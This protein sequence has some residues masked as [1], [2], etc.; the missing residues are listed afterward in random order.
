MSVSMGDGGSWRVAVG[1]L[2][3][4]GGG[5]E[6]KDGRGWKLTNQEPFDPPTPPHRA[7]CSSAIEK[8]SYPPVSIPKSALI[9]STLVPLLE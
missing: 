4:A 2:P 9:S 7:S 6:V 8:L 3:W 5:A 1:G